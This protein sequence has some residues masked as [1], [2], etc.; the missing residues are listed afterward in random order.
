MREFNRRQ[1]VAA[2]AVSG[3]LLPGM[4]QA[5]TRVLTPSGNEGP[6]YPDQL[7]LD[8]DNDLVKLGSDGKQAAGQVFHL[9]GEVVN[10]AGKPFRGFTLEIWQCDA[11]GVY[12]H[13]GDSGRGR[14]DPNFQGFGT[15]LTSQS[16]GYRFRTITPVSYP[17]RTPHIHFKIKAPNRREFT[18]QM[19]L[20]GHPRNGA[21]FLYRQLGNSTAQRAASVS[22]LPAPEL[23]R[24]AVKG[25]FD[26]VLI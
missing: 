13:S 5:A 21:D 14:F 9:M 19:Y 10:K 2:G 17:G 24:D 12:S 6:F 4:V 22:L 7:P 20:A 3:I 26:I 23:D 1:I 16:G 11:N 18:S 25:T 8:T 15:T